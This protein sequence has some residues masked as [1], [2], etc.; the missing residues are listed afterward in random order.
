MTDLPP[1]GAPSPAPVPAPA[2]SP[3][4]NGGGGPCSDEPF[5]VGVL[6]D[7]S[8]LCD[9]IEDRPRACVDYADEIDE[10]SQLLNKAALRTRRKAA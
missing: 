3:N 2:A 7:V 10:M 9:W 5:V 1:S 4:P 8:R 6:K